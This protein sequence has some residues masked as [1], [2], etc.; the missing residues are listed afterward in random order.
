MRKEELESEAQSQC[1]FQRPFESSLETLDLTDDFGF[2]EAFD[3][4]E[5]QEEQHCYYHPEVGVD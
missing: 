2:L 4:F 3:C 1:K 5:W